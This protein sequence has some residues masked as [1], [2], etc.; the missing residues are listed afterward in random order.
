MYPQMSKIIHKNAKIFKCQGH[1]E[2]IE[3]NIIDSV[4]KTV[5]FLIG[6]S[7]TAELVSLDLQP[8]GVHVMCSKWRLLTAHRAG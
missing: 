4:D 5:G 8:C 7:L 3:E 1:K 2:I 6:Q